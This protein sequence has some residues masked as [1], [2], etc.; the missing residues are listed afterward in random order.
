M[1]SKPANATWPTY[2]VALIFTVAAAFPFVWMAISSL[3]SSQELYSVPPTWLPRS[4]TFQNYANVLFNSNI[5][6]YFL[7]SVVISVGASAVAILL[8][9]L[10]A[11]GFARFRFHGKR[12]L[13]AS[14]LVSQLLPTA[15]IIV[16]LYITFSSL[17]LVNTYAGLIIVYLIHT[18][19]L[20]VWML[21]G[22]FRAIP[23]E[24]EEAALIDGASRLLILFRIVLPLSI[25][26]IVST[27]VYSF[28]SSWN[29]FI[30]ALVFATD[31][32]VKTLPIGLAEFTSEF[33]TDWGAVMAASMLMTLPIVILFFGIQKLF[34]GGM[35]SGATKG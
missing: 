22:Y 25:P 19:P 1:T 20:C 9:I 4:L 27:L 24:V 29:E 14:I 13:Q 5:P 7:N 18:L 16:P 3:K 6:R 2:L 10:A 31:S 30:F 21:I 33:N 12:A 23:Y 32:S 8:A 28:V 11:Y 26:G 35:T 17:G 15:T 34:V